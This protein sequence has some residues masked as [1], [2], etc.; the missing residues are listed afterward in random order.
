MNIPK[1][2]ELFRNEITRKGFRQATIKN[3]VSC[4]ECFLRHFDGKVTEPVK[5][6][7]Q[8]IK[9]YLS[10]FKTQN[11]QRSNHS[12][13]KCFYLYT[14]KQPNKF[15]YIEYCKRDRKLPIVLSTDEIQKL[16]NICKNIKH[17]AILA[18]LYSA[19]LRVS[20]VINLKITHI[21][22]SRMV[23]NIINAKGGKDRQVMLNQN[24]LELLR[25]YYKMYRPKDFL[26]NGQNSEQYSSRSINEFLKTYAEKAGIEN[27]R[28]YAH[29]MRHTSFTHMVENGT[30][31]N[32][33]Q[34]LAGHSSVK[35]T[36]LYTHIS[37]NLISNIQSP[38]ANIQL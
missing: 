16:F 24:V 37:H 26:F 14:L 19:G 5:I 23:I 30:D 20:E 12:A 17:R 36:L 2:I 21:D 18:L 1:Y 32:M 3:Y 8:Q 38:I 29:L 25:N 33:I 34:K 13:I 31:I 27:K 11:T 6:N 28:I 15:K 22:S 35:T 9:E 7:E 10:T 4:I